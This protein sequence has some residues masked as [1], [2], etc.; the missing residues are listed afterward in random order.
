M[1]VLPRRRVFCAV[2][3]VSIIYRVR[4]KD[5]TDEVEGRIVNTHEAH[6]AKCWPRWRDLPS[7]S[8][9]LGSPI[10]RGYFRIVAV[11]SGLYT[12]RLRL[13]GRRPSWN[14]RFTPERLAGTEASRPR[15]LA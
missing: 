15:Y 11:P 3:L 6:S 2:L 7:N 12:V 1:P 13:I 5:V 4:S 9:E 14:S 8:R 10:K